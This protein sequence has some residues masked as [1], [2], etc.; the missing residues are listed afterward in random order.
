MKCFFAHHLLCFEN[1]VE[2]SS[3]NYRSVFISPLYLSYPTIPKVLNHESFFRNLDR[4][5]KNLAKQNFTSSA[6]IKL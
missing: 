2:I 3:F 5:L 4:D 1:N 6:V